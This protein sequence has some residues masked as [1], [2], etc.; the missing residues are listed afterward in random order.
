VFLIILEKM[1]RKLRFLSLT[2]LAEMF[3]FVQLMG[4]RIQWQSYN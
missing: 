4:K 3:A 1:E 2:G